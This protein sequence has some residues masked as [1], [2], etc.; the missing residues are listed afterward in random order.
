MYTAKIYK[1]PVCPSVCEGLNT[2][3]VIKKK[4]KERIIYT[5]KNVGTWVYLQR[6]ILS[7]RRQFPKFLNCMIPFM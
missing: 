3:S 2:E 6:I 5:C 4:K 1:E 7:E